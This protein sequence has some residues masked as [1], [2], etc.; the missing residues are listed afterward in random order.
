VLTLILPLEQQQVLAAA[1]REA[2]LRE[3]GGVLM[4]EHVGPNTFVVREITVHRRGAVA[5]FVRRIEDAIG[6][7]RSYFQETGHD[8]A[9]F[10]YIGEWHSHPSFPPFP[11]KTDDL[12]MLQI[13]QDESVG[14]HFVVLLIAK[15]RSEGELI[16]TVHTYLPDGKRVQSNLLLREG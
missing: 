3:V 5:S 6:R 7:L 16:S 10:N 8:Y 15:L 14:A 4:G 1:L 13:V 2:G 9:R 11:S 12:S